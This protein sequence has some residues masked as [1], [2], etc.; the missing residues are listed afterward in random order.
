MKT[1]LLSLAV[2]ISNAAHAG[3]T[4]WGNLYLANTGG[5]RMMQVDPSDAQLV[6]A[7]VDGS[8]G[9][10]LSISCGPNGSFLNLG[11]VGQGDPFMGS[12]ETIT[13]IFDGNTAVR[14][15]RFSYAGGNYQSQLQPQTLAKITTH[16]T[17]LLISENA[18]F[19]DTFTLTGSAHSIE[20]MRCLGG[21]T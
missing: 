17:V 12:E 6:T 21:K 13:A 20:A 16:G 10:R 1:V 11:R 4:E 19:S 5:S 7:F 18:A 8:S 15:G 2:F 9:H 3:V 14:I